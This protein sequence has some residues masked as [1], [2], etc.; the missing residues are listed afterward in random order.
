MRCVFPLRIIML[1]EQYLTINS[2]LGIIMRESRE[3]RRRRLLEKARAGVTEAYSSADHSII[4][5]INAYK[6]L[7]KA[8]QIVF[9]RLE[10]WYSI[11]FPNVGIANQE[12]YMNLVA[13]VQKKEDAS[14]AQLQQFMG[15]N[16]GRI[17]A[18]IE[19]QEKREPMADGEYAAI[20]SLALEGLRINE[21]QKKL[22]S[23]ISE[24]A[25]QY[26]PNITYLIDYKLAAELLSKAGSLT[27]LATMPASTIQLL[28]AE[29]A[30]FKHIRFGSRPPKY[31]I[32]FKLPEITNAPKR[33]KGRLA[34][35]YATKISIA[36]RADA[37]T[38]NFIA[39][40]L[41]EQLEKAAKEQAENHK[42]DDNTERP[43][44]DR[45]QYTRGTRDTGNR[46]FHRDFRNR[47]GRENR[48]RKNYPYN[49]RQ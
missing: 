40:R 38:K 23:Y 16:A 13:H 47:N 2:Y 42:N 15:E 1:S 3:E 39:G 9:E 6:E 41:K 31:G 43:R 24:A 14:E 17:A 19:N 7:D 48:E 35:I 45:N 25:K 4:Q 11:Y 46:G 18:A 37:F 34:R 28:G 30:L 10:E 5:A 26:M 36:S 12:A 49:R 29:K 44:Q 20:K 33:Q 8:K 32:L 22:D 27:K 21:L